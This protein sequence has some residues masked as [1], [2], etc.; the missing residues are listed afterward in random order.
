MKK[1]SG[2]EISKQA[3]NIFVQSGIYELRRM[4]GN[5]S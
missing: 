2:I 3:F 1:P 5:Q 4:P